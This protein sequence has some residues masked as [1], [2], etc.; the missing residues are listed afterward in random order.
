MVLLSQVNLKV[1]FKNNYFI[2]LFLSVETI[3]D[4]M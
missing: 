4:L 2:F 3:S 1:H